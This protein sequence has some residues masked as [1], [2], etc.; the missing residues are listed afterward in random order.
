MDDL[1]GTVGGTVSSSSAGLGGEALRCSNLPLSQGALNDATSLLEGPQRQLGQVVNASGI[2]PAVLQN[3]LTV[4]QG[5]V[6][7]S[8]S[9][10]RVVSGDRCPG[11]IAQA[12]TKPLSEPLRT[13]MVGGAD[14]TEFA[15]EGRVEG[16]SN[17]A[18][19]Q[20]G[21]GVGMVGCWRYGKACVYWYA[22][23]VAS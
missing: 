8:S 11:V 3:P 5:L 15:A 1:L 20:A 4:S 14:A 2:R 6:G 9:T 19:E 7:H 13:R 17:W 22:I 21:P 16:W 12:P 10:Q 23:T 18:A